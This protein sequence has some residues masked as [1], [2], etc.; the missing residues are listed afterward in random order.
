MN[1]NLLGCE[2]KFGNSSNSLQNKF[3]ADDP[4]G[5]LKPGTGKPQRSDRE[6]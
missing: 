2:L 4:S 6:V 5:L 3:L 1:T